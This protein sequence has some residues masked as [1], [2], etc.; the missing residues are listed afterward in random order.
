MQTKVKTNSKIKILF[1]TEIVEIKGEGKV[2]AVTLKNNQDN[3]VSTVPVDGVFMAIGHKPASEIFKGQL[4]L[5]EAGF[6]KI[7]KPHSVTSVPGVFVAGDVADPYYKQA[8]TAAGSG[9][10]AA[11]DTLKY[12][13]NL[14]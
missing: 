14:R 9:C 11:L 2:S 5:N 13:E 7:V 12:L 6:I 3:N 1:N 10:A 8:I 4:G